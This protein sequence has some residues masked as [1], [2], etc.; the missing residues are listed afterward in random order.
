MT[1]SETQFE[2]I[3]AEEFYPILKSFEST[4]IWC[5][6]K[7]IIVNAILLTITFIIFNNI[8]KNPESLQYAYYYLLALIAP[9]IMSYYLT[10][11][12]N[13]Q[14]KKTLK[15]DC[16]EEIMK[17]FQFLEWHKYPLYNEI[18]LEHSSLFSRCDKKTSEDAFSGTHKGVKFKIEETSV[19]TKASMLD[20]QTFKGIIMDFENNQPNKARTIVTTQ[21]DVLVKNKN[22]KVFTGITF[23]ALIF[24][25]AFH[26]CINGRFPTAEIISLLVTFGIFLTIWYFV[27]KNQ[28]RNKL[29]LNTVK[30]ENSKFEKTFTVYSDNKNEAI[31]LITPIFMEKLINLQNSFNA[32]NVKCSFYENKIMF[33]INT[34]KDLFEI[35]TI[36]SSTKNPKQLKQLFT[37]LESVLKM[38]EHFKL[39]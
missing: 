38:I 3:Y 2:E 32:N 21:N 31:H 26:Q 17:K 34:N 1:I 24:L 29:E 4:R 16:Q 23:F 12:I 5:V 36:F 15:E 39:N 19:Y 7:C 27:L 28:F 37:E 22:I 25:I 13:N 33:A 8:F 10:T 14:F 30:L 35:G 18:E 9:I 20:R 11:V 6:T